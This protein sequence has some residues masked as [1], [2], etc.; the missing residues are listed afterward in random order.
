MIRDDVSVRKG[1]TLSS[2][3][4]KAQNVTMDDYYD[5]DRRVDSMES[6]VTVLLSKVIKAKTKYLLFYD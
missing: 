6:S 2:Q 3:D 5:L 4:S 1:S